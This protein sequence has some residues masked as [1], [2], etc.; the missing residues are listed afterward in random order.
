MTTL[1]K[2]A[3]TET[4]KSLLAEKGEDYI[5]PGAGRHCTYSEGDGAPS[6][7]VGHVVAALDTEMFERIV[8]VER[9][10]GE[11]WSAAQMFSEGFGDDRI[12]V[13]T[14][15]KVLAVALQAAQYVQDTGASWGNAVKAYNEIIKGNISSIYG[16]PGAEYL[17]VLNKYQKY[18]E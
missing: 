7:I 11:S 3:V 4:L 16:D 8:E 9:Y 15:S 6:C 10:D 18:P 13:S 12:V 5:Y 17:A 1:T 14:D 2:N